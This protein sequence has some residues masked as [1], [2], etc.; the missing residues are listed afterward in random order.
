M[1]IHGYEPLPQVMQEL[2][3]LMAHY[4][5]EVGQVPQ[6]LAL[7]LSARKNLC[8]HPEVCLVGRGECCV[9]FDPTQVSKGEDGKAVDSG[10]HKLTASFVRKAH[11]KDKRTPVCLFYEVCCTGV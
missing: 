2:K 1:C 10:C 9:T 6:M 8:I 4:Q 11:L 7:A 5:R 3:R